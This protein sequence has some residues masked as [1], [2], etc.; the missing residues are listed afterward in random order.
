MAQNQPRKMG[1]RRGSRRPLPPRVAGERDSV[2]RLGTI[3]FCKTPAGSSGRWI[4]FW[5]CQFSEPV[6]SQCCLRAVESDSP[7]TRGGRGL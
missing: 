1:A 5:R 6:K 3:E 4:R 2:V 7:A